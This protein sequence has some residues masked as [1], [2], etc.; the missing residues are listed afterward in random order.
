MSNIEMIRLIKETLG[1]YK[2][3]ITN[4]LINDIA[5][6]STTFANCKINVGQMGGAEG[7]ALSLI[8]LLTEEEDNG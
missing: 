3:M 8:E 2:Q 7:F 5:N 1:D 6:P 4:N